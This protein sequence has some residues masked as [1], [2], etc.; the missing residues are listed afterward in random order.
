MKIVC[1][2]DTHGQHNYF[3]KAKHVQLPEGDVLVHA[4]D[5]TSRGFD[6][7][8]FAFIN[9]MYDQDYAHKIVV[10]GNHDAF[11]ESN[12]FEVADAMA[13]AGIH[14]LCDSGVVI[15]GVHFY[16]SPW[17]PIFMDWHFMKSEVQLMDRWKRIPETTDVLVTHGPPLNIADKNYRGESY[18]SYALLEH[19]RRVK[20]KVHIFGHIH[21]GRNSQGMMPT[22]VENTSFVN[23]SFLDDCYDPYG[24]V[25]PVIEL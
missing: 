23:A 8:T 18:G 17:T 13:F 7:E 3:N 25:Q 20:P 5:T 24:I 1:L 4:G 14:Y 11:Y 6:I 12:P 19:V 15:N 2:S 21:E 22:L 9:W 16:G 10:A